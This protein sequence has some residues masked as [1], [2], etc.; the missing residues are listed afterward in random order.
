M[1]NAKAVGSDAE[2]RRPNHGATEQLAAKKPAKGLES[3]KQ[4]VVGYRRGYR[5]AEPKN[6]I[7][8]QFTIAVF[9]SSSALEFDELAALK[10]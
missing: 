6:M 7:I 3:H 10:G 8:F 2:I 5:L 9:E 4:K 1:G